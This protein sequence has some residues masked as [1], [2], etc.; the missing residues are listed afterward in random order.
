M[1]LSDHIM[2]TSVSSHFQ[3]EMMVESVVLARDQYLKQVW[4]L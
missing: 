4:S 1:T 3:F 2:M